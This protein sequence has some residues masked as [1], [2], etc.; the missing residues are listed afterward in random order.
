MAP[1]TCAIVSENIAG[2][3][4]VIAHAREGLATGGFEVKRMILGVVVIMGLGVGCATAAPP[5]QAP[6]ST[7]Q[8]QQADKT[9]V[10]DTKKDLD[11]TLICESTPVTGSHIPRKVCRTL[12]QV[13][14]ERE[15]AQKA[16]REAE[17][18]NRDFN[19]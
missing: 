1:R 13:E 18:V 11:R 2:V 3:R 6:N 7:A 8:S 14:Q 10:A 15:A 16:I 9:A 19:Q 5:Q 4:R 17:K 12:R